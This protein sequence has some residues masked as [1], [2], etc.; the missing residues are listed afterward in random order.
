MAHNDRSVFWSQ[1]RRTITLAV[2]VL[3]SLSGL[4]LWFASKGFPVPDGDSIY[5]YPVMLD[6]ASGHGFSNHFS[7][8]VQPFDPTGEGRLVYHGYLYPLLV[9]SLAWK[10]CY[11]SIEL[12]VAAFQIMALASCFGLFRLAQRGTPSAGSATGR[13]MLV[14][15]TLACATVISGLAARAETI[16]IPIIATG[17]ILLYTL[18]FRW[19]GLVCGLGI[20]LLAAAHPIG[21]LLSGLLVAMYVFARQDYWPAF[22]FLLTAAGVAAVTWATTF[23][24]YPYSLSEWVGGLL[25]NG[26]NV[27]PNP[28]TGPDSSLLYR[29]ILQPSATGYGCIYLVG[30]FVL[31]YHCRQSAAF[32]RSKFAFVLCAVPVLFA[33]YNYGFRAPVQ[34]YNLLLFAPL[35]IALLVHFCSPRGNRVLQ[36][37]AIGLFGL[38][39]LGFA[40]KVLLF[41]WFLRDGLA[42]DAAGQQLAEIRREFPGR[43]AISGGLFTLVD[44]YDGI[45]EYYDGNTAATVVMQQAYRGAGT[46]PVVPGYRLVR[47]YFCPVNPRVFGVPVAHSVQGYNFALYR[48]MDLERNETTR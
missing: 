8:F 40:Q 20:G 46:A 6:R 27:L 21:S 1:R 5:Y 15:A 13:I 17:V 2:F 14:T 36:F 35:V 11:A 30:G 34:N 31:V 9:G 24:A 41:P 48:R 43:V 7:R 3:G 38:A 37:A 45:E 18:P 39:S 23:W 32:I 4:L 33:I 47:S 26:R 28:T 19:H 22:R 25:A 44:R 16:G 29:W 42:R 12:V 10:P